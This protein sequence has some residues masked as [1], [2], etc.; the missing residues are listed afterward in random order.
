MKHLLP[1]LL[2]FS[3]SLLQAADTYQSNDTLYV[4]ARSG[5]NVRQEASTGSKI[6][7][8]LLPG[9]WI[10]I[11]AKPKR[12]YSLTAIAPYSA[13]QADIEYPEDFTDTAY[14]LKGNWVQ[15]ESEHVNGFVIDMYLLDLIPPESPMSVQR[16][17]ELLEGEPIQSDT[18]WQSDGQLNRNLDIYSYE[19]KSTAGIIV[20]G[21][22]GEGAIDESLGI[23]GLSLEE[24]FV[25]YNYFSALEDGLRRK[26]GEA[27]LALVRHNDEMIALTEDELCYISISVR[28][29]IL[30]IGTGCSC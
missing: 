26:N 9:E 5:L 19:G 23:P 22:S 12:Q 21:S 17:F 16:Y 25:F 8:K 29:G 7:G 13:S 4:W 27:A 18:I 2:F 6:L 30:W 15:I 3:F 28:E 1:F 14:Q 11:I 24:G 10:R 20:Q